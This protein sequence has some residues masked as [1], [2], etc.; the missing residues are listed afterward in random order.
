[1]QFGL[2]F[3]A[4]AAAIAALTAHA[5]PAVGPSILR[6]SPHSHFPSFPDPRTTDRRACLHLHRHQLL[7]R[8][9][10]RNTTSMGFLLSGCRGLG[11]QYDLRDNGLA[12]GWKGQGGQGS[13][14]RLPA[15]PNQRYVVRTKVGY[16]MDRD[17]PDL[18]GVEFSKSIESMIWKTEVV[19]LS[20]QK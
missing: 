7:R 13:G 16:G 5:A 17:G 3:V 8:L 12:F 9:H 2:N 11:I 1:M 4:L 20:S 14:V 18:Q 6:K 15:M 10:L 19:H